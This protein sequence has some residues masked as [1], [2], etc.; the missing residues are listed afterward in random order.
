MWPFSRILI[1]KGLIVNGRNVRFAAKQ[2][3]SVKIVFEDATEHWVKC[4]SV[5][6][7][8]KLVECIGEIL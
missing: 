8:E 2:G 4:E 7:A 1:C 6:A 3:S 5:E